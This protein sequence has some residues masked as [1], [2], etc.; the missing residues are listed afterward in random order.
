M[1]E[2]ERIMTPV[3]IHGPPGLT[4]DTTRAL[5]VPSPLAELAGLCGK[6]W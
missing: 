3:F 6:L 4:W 1:P 2:P 5:T